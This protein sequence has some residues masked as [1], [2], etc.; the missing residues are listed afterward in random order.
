VQPDRR[1]GTILVGHRVE[2]LLGRGGMGYVYKAEHLTLGRKVALKVLAPQLS[3]DDEYRN[4]FLLES[5]MAARLDH[6]NIVPI[7]EAGEADDV[8]YISMRF[9]D[10]EDLAGI[11]EREGRLEPARAVELLGQ[12][13]G[14]LD[15]AHANGL[16]HRDVKPANVLVTAPAAPGGPEHAWLCDFGLVKSFDTPTLQRL[17]ATGMFMG[18]I[19]YT[20]PEQIEARRLDG[21]A[22]VY[23]LGCLLFECLTGVVPF[24]RENDVQTLYAHIHEAPP[25]VGSIQPHLPAT[26]DPVFAK[27]LA[28]NRNERFATCG[29]MI[30]AARQAL[31]AGPVAPAAPPAGPPWAGQPYPPQQQPPA[32]PYAPVGGQV[33]QPGY[34]AQP[35]Q[36]FGYG[37]GGYG[38]PGAAPSRA[39]RHQ[40]G[41]RRTGLIVAGVVLAVL[42]VIGL[43]VASN[44]LSGLYAQS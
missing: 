44:W 17:T 35:P 43:V 24:E 23:A 12:V 2:G 27:A 28:K 20:S 22:D 36:P 7:Y 6:P 21:R 38:N 39:A 31:A 34:G 19:Q 33:G 5:R 40:G 15:A 1:I 26:L 11:L 41:G 10:G 29:E 18:T 16:V 8:L 25:A 14:A 37:S 30:Q 13:G 9:I 4:R 32:Q 3:R 42:V